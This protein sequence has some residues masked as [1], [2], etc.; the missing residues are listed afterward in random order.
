MEPPFSLY[1]YDVTNN[2]HSVSLRHMSSTTSATL[3][4]RLTAPESHPLI[5]KQKSSL[6]KKFSTTKAAALSD[7][8]KLAWLLV[9]AGRETEAREI[10]D[11]LTENIAFTG[12]FNIWTPVS[13]AVALS[14]R[15]A[16]LANQDT[17]SYASTLAAHPALAVMDRGRFDA[18]VA[19]PLK[20]I[21][22]LIAEK[23]SQRTT[24]SLANDCS[25]A[26]YFRESAVPG[27]YY[28]Q[29]IDRAAFDD[30]IQQGVNHM[31]TFLNA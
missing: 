25:E 28:E 22:R 7:T 3:L 2:A 23:P 15:L 29:W 13:Q 4:D 6:A 31:Q 12:D 5:A 24:L 10:S 9:G 21:T 27:M 26:T 11:W 16:R 19:Q 17:S 14:A 18:W 1:R 30:A 8:V 20:E